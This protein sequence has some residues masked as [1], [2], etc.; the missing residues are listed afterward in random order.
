MRIRRVFSPI[1]RLWSSSRICRYAVC[2]AAAV[3]AAAAAWIAAPYCLADPLAEIRD[4]PTVRM[5]FSPGGECIAVRRAADDSWR[6]PV[7]LDKIS[8]HVVKVILAAEDARF[9][10]HGGVDYA[11]L[12]RAFRQDMAAFRR[13]SGAS[14]ITMQLVSLP[15]AGRR[16]NLWRKFR[17]ILRARAVEL[18]HSK[19]EILTEYLNRVLFGGLCYGIESASRYYFGVSASELNFDEAVMLCGLPQKPNAYRP[20][21][22]PG[23][24]RERMRL[25]LHLLVRR[26]VI[27]PERAAEILRHPQLRFRDFRKPFAW[28]GLEQFGELSHASVMALTEAG[29]AETVTGSVIPEWTRE[30]A[31]LLRRSFA[32]RPGVHDAAAVVIENATGRVRVLC[33]VSAPDSDAAEI[34][35][36]RVVRS[37][38]SALKPFIYLEGAAAGMI[39]PDTV[40]LD[41]PVR[42]GNYAPGNFD[43]SFRGRVTAEQALVDSLNTPVV[44]LLAELG[45]KRVLE[46]FRAFGLLGEKSREV[47]GLALALGS[48]GHTLIDMTNAYSALARGGVRREWTMLENTPP[49]PGE[50]VAPESACRMILRMLA[51]R[52]MPGARFAC[53]WKTGTS[54]N[55]CDSW[56]FAATREYAVG[57]WF[58]NHNGRPVPGMT[59]RGMAVPAAAEIL[60]LLYA[61]KY[62]EP[63]AE[64]GLVPAEICAASGLR[65]GAR[66]EKRSATTVCADIPLRECETCRREGAPE[67]VRI[68]LPKPESYVGEASG[69]KLPLR[70]SRAGTWFVDGVRLCDGASAE[71][72][73]PPGPHTVTLF[74]PDGASASVRLSVRRGVPGRK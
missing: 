2:A 36:A 42:F 71:H 24:A 35:G 16:K 67:S 27:P 4:L 25:V 51:S 26:G 54:S 64:T 15:E 43:G 57:V 61:G 41:A 21:L 73:F 74:A 63:F 34:N 68:L 40:L 58:G 23:R 72:V 19:E 6:R 22:H 49:A 28:R 11:A 56:C 48:A 59:G 62:P 52:P 69:A 20:D 53:A 37:A 55:F 30:T 32:A 39:A 8:P 44:R 18:H 9:F 12:L 60:D 46:R 3:I 50:R 7:P 29:D 14:T 5:V 65:P 31:A 70:G 17:Q 45:E 1:R 13:V 33:G 47:N 66:C 38:G 10:E